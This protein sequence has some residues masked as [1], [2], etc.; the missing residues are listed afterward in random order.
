MWRDKDVSRDVNEKIGFREFF[1]SELGAHARD[2]LASG[3]RH[4][5]REDDD[6]VLNGLV[7]QN[8]DK[9]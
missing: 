3:G 5:A 8:L 1:K 6:S 2:D 9:S 7:V 4:V